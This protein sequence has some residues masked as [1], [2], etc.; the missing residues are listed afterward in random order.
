MFMTRMHFRAWTFM[1]VRLMK[2]KVWQ[3]F[4]CSSNTWAVFVF[5]RLR[6]SLG[7]WV[8]T[9]RCQ[10]PKTMGFMTCLAYQKFRSSP[11]K[12]RI[13]P[14]AW[15]L[16]ECIDFFDFDF[17]FP[18]PQEKKY[19][20]RYTKSVFF[21]LHPTDLTVD[22]SEIP[23]NHLRFFKNIVNSKKSG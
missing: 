9:P 17:F 10:W 1:L 16:L 23:N 19:I 3:F 13:Q 20:I 14:S 6:K 22:G 7:L 4:F 18:H 5:S 8:C 11:K 2:K 15:F 12:T 21:S